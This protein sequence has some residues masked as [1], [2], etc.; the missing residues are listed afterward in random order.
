MNKGFTLL[1]V[2]VAMF[3]VVFGLVAVISLVSFITG[4]LRSTQSNIEAVNLAQEGIEITRNIRDTNWKNNQD[5]K[6]GLGEG[7]WRVHYL[8]EPLLS[9]QDAALKRDSSGFYN[10]DSGTNT[11][12]KRKINISYDTDSDNG[13]SYIRVKSIL[14]WQIKNKNYNITL[15]DR[16]YDWK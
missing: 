5:F 15:E 1:E 3:I 12:F 10:Y 16:L 6:T 9:Y 14:T 11:A 2:L 13:A 4:S 8:S 7:D